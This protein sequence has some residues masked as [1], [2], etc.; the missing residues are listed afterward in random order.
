MWLE[1]KKYGQYYQ[2]IGVGAYIENLNAF[3]T[4]I[5]YGRLL[6]SISGKHALYL[7]YDTSKLSCSCY[8]LFVK[9]HQH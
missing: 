7:Y 2:L 1:F 3:V 8:S 9:V 6:H 4:F 5:L